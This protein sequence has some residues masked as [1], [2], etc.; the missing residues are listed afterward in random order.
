MI[1]FRGDL[2][3]SSYS[4]PTETGDDTAYYPKDLLSYWFASG[5]ILDV[6]AIINVDVE[7]FEISGTWRITALK[8]EEVTIFYVQIKTLCE[9][10]I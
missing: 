7:E 10:Y 3:S 5:K 1:L 4:Q 8:G 2:V 9:E 6:T